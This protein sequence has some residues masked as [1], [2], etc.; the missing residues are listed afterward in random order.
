MSKNLFLKEGVLDFL[1]MKLLFKLK[2]LNHNIQIM[3]DKQQQAPYTLC[4]GS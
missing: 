1:Q 3:I 2:K 4:F